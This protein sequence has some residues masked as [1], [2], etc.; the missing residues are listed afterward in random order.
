MKQDR[1]DH[2][3]WAPS[4]AMT[5]DLW[6][7]AIPSS[8]KTHLRIAYELPISCCSAVVTVTVANR[9]M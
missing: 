4:K 2:V 5:V 7:K 9:V 8:G 1:A 6:R 3:D